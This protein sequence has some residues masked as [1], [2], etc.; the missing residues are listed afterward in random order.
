[1]WTVREI[2]GVSICCIVLFSL[3]GLLG[4][5]ASEK[6]RRTGGPFYFQ[7][8]EMKTTSDIPIMPMNPVSEKEALKLALYGIA[9]YDEQG[10]L[11]SFTVMKE[12][13]I[14]WLSEYYYNGGHVEKEKHFSQEKG[15]VN[16]KYYYDS[17]G[18]LVKREKVKK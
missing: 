11:V 14:D 4:C 9:Y 6:H 7:K 8:V 12:G 18:A 1:M 17:T 5:H 2:I 15:E 16:Y 10:R 3:S 13:K